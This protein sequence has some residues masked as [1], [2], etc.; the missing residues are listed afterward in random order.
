[1]WIL[2]TALKWKKKEKNMEEEVKDKKKGME[3]EGWTE[4]RR[5]G[6]KKKRNWSVREKKQA[7]EDSEGHLGLLARPLWGDDGTGTVSCL[8]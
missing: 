8:S 2:I 1:M 3:K 6:G 4:G 5:E 7:S